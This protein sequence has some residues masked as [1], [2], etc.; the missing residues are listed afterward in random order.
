MKV[1]DLIIYLV[2]YIRERKYF[3]MLV[4][5]LYLSSYSLSV[6]DPYFLT[7]NSS[8]NPICPYKSDH[9]IPQ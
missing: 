2:C 6:Q 4:S 9:L 7:V 8:S 5:Y 3:L 1:V